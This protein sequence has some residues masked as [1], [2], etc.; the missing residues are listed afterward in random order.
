MSFTKV[1]LSIWLRYLGVLG[2]TAVFLIIVGCSTSPL[3]TP[4]PVPQPR[5]YPYPPASTG[6]GPTP[7]K[8][9][10]TNRENV[11]IVSPE[12]SNQ[13]S[14]VVDDS[15]PQ[16]MASLELVDVGRRNIE[17][18]NVDQGISMLERAIS[19]D[20]Y[21]RRAYY[22][23]SVAWLKKN[24]PSRAL[25]F[26]KKAELLCQGRKR[27]LKKIYLLERDIYLRMGNKDKA[28]MYQWKADK[29]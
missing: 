12:E 28:D 24:Q 26:A 11:V 16:H 29:L 13:P 17:A 21:N 27:E 23:L 3:Y 20:A 10:A 22:Y 19:L 7:E 4:Q 15:S 8:G 6:K 14:P 9:I 1:N 25:E 2:V 18:G 5:K